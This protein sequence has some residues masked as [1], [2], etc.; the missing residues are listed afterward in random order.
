MSVELVS[1]VS[2]THAISTFP[3][4]SRS[5]VSFFFSVLLKSSISMVIIRSRWFP[6][7]SPMSLLVLDFQLFMRL[8]NLCVYAFM[9]LCVFVYLPYVCFFFVCCPG[10]F[11]CGV[12]H[13]SFFFVQLCFPFFVILID[14]IVVFLV[15]FLFGLCC[16]VCAA[17]GGIGGTGG[18]LVAFLGRSDLRRG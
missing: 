11:F 7:L 17:L 16:C 1:C 9:R 8:W 10:L 13:F 4:S 18:V 6:A 15:F 14:L 3:C 12:D 5:V 2:C